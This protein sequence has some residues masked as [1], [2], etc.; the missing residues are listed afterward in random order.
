[1]LAVID[2]DMKDLIKKLTID[3][4]F[5]FSG[6]RKELI[7]ILQDTRV[8]NFKLVDHSEI[9]LYPDISWGTIVFTGGL[10]GLQVE[11]INIRVKTSPLGPG[12][13][14]INFRT[15]I[16][17]EHYFMVGLFVF[18]FIAATFSNESWWIFPYIFG[19]WIISH[20]WF[21]F[22]YRAQENYLIEKVVKKL[23]LVKM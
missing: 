5:V 19:L 11:G 2:Q 23:R 4:D 18:F 21:Q 20:S 1:V 12:R 7:S 10:Q 8:V 17:P 6:E 9:K 14:K 3:R 22:I 16:R 15:R 13:I